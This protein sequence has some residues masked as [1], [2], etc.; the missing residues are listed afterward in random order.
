MPAITYL[1]FSVAV[2]R[3]RCRNFGL[4]YLKASTTGCAAR[5]F[6]RGVPHLR[7]FG[8]GSKVR[9]VPA[10]PLAREHIHD[11]LAA[12]GH[13]E[14]ADGPLFRPLKN[15]AERGGTNRPLTH[16]AVYCAHRRENGLFLPK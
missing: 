9:Y 5:N 13:G 14:N 15:P 3:L 2:E 11:Y 4:R 16:E 10:H 6:R 7:V 8:K 1:R 12:A